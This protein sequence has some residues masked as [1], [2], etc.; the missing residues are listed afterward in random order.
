[1]LGRLRL[2]ERH[3][4]QRQ[5]LDVIVADQADVHLASLDQLLDDRRLVELRVN[6]LDSLLQ[7]R[8]ILHDR[9]LRD[10]DRRVLE[11][12]LDNEWKAQLGGAHQRVAI[13]KL[14]E[15]RHPDA[16]IGE[17][18]LGQRLVARD[19]QCGRRRP[20]IAIAIHIQ[21]R[22]N[23]VLMACVLAE[24]L[25]AVKHELGLKR[26]QLRE[27]RPDVIADSDHEHIVLTRDQRARD[28][29]FRLLGLLLDLALEIRVFPLG[30]KRVEDD[31]DLHNATRS[32]SRETV[33]KAMRITRPPSR[34]T[35]GS[36]NIAV[37]R[38]PV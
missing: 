26:R 17:N 20:R 3:F 7:A 6:E 33:F 35:A 15:R 8:V 27:H 29:V 22:S 2:A 14:R 32:I 23:R 31:R 1:M 11:Q 12:W 5:D 13:V 9:G 10:T 24:A 28:V 25:A 4:R 36:S 37:R 38:L 16:V 18:L 34:P 19:E 30:M 21:Q